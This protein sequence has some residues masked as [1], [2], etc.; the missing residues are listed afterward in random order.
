MWV[1]GEVL[2]THLRSVSRGERLE[3]TPR[4]TAEEVTDEEHFDTGGEEE[5]EDGAGHEGHGELIRLAS[6]Y[7][8]NVKSQN[9]PCKHVENRIAAGGSR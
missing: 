9:I 4:D 1:S 3:D 8:T 2:I 5:D 6:F 7:C